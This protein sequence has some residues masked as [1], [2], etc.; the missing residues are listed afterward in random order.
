MNSLFS[1]CSSLKS[2]DLSNINTS[3]VNRMASMFSECNSLESIDLSNFDTSLIKNMNSMLYGCNSLESI[4]LSYFNTSLVNK[5][6]S[7]FSGCESL[8]VLDISSFDMTLINDIPNMFTDVK[9]L[10]YIN[11]YNTQD[12]KRLFSESALKDMPE[13]IVCQKEDLVHDKT[14]KCCYF[15]METDLCEIT[16]YMIVYYGRDVEYENN[17]NNKYRNDI[18]FIVR[19]GYS[20]KINPSD[21]LSIRSGSKIKIYYESP[22]ETL[23]NF[24]DTNFDEKAEGI[25]SIDLSHFDSTKIT[26]MNN[27]FRF[28]FIKF[29]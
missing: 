21:K 18:S 12:P 6:N 9:N 17:F 2:I 5:M 3:L 20:P 10:K 14:N 8:K 13:L 4:D 16:N 29:N 19:G 24:F 26:N 23:E 15:D 25:V 11:L 7:M 28:K 1:G 22:I 27:V